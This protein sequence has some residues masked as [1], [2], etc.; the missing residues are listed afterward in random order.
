MPEMTPL[1]LDDLRRKLAAATKGPW[2]LDHDDHA[3]DAYACGL[4]VSQPDWIV[5]PDDDHDPAA[6]DQILANNRFIVAAVNLALPMVEEIERLREDVRFLSQLL[7]ESL[8]G[9]GAHARTKI[10][11]DDIARIRMEFSR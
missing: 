1:D 3:V 6:E 5:P 11:Q 8:N 9:W 7:N 2:R 10:E 4:S